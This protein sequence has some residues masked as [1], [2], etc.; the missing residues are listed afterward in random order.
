MSTKVQRSE[1]LDYETYSE[2][3]NGIRDRILSIKAPRR[4]HV[5]EVFTFLFENGETIRYQIQEMMR[6]EKMVKESAIQHELDTYN[7]LLGGP[8]E[9]GCALLIEIDDREER[10]RKLSSWVK[11]P[12]HLY[13]KLEDGSRVYAT[14]DPSQVGEDRLSAV[15]YLKFDTHGQVPVALGSDLPEITVETGLSP[16]QREAL[17]Q[18]LAM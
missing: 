1:L 8:G 14:Y 15:Q 17:R 2:R 10:K 12:A 7:G 3:R 11:L 13:A 4:I 6:A 18:D 16:E 5:G 9:L